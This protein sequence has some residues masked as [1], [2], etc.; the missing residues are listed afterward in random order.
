[1]IKQST[2]KGLVIEAVLKTLSDT[3]CKAGKAEVIPMWAW[4]AA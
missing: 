2:K 1:M 4:H 3:C